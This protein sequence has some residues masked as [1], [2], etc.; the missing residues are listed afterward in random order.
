MECK[1]KGLH[2][3]I[4]IV[5]NK[6]MGC[7]TKGYNF[8]IVHLPQN[9]LSFWFIF[10]IYHRELRIR[11]IWSVHF[12]RAV[13]KIWKGK[14]L[15]SS[16]RTRQADKDVVAPTRRPRWWIWRMRGDYSLT[17]QRISTLSE[18]TGQ[19]TSTTPQD[20][21][22]TKKGAPKL[23]NIKIVICKLRAWL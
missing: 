1:S 4:Y 10:L 23:I 5:H 13:L 11:P 16:R 21:N 3:V 15:W 12:G 17:L 2:E 20:G 22:E 19:N 9:D 7:R 18:E 8:I 6:L 14:A